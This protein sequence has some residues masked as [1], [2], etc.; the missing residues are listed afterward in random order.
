MKE[1]KNTEHRKRFIIDYKGTELLV[2]SLAV[3]IKQSLRPIF[4]E[5]CSLDPIARGGY[6]VLGMLLYPL[7]LDHATLNKPKKPCASCL[8]VDDA[9][10]SGARLA[11]A[12]QASTVDSIYIVL[13][14]A[15]QG[16]VDAI[17][18]AEPRVKQVFVAKIL[19]DLGPEKYGSEYQHWQDRRM[20]QLEGKRYWVGVPELVSFPWSE[21]DSVWWNDDTQQLE[22]GWLYRSPDQCLKNRSELSPPL[23]ITGRPEYRLPD[24]TAYRLKKEESVQLL[25]VDS[26]E[27]F[28]L[29]GTASTMWQALVKYG[30]TETTL[31]YLT[32]VYK[33]DQSLLKEDLTLFIDDA[34]SKRLLEKIV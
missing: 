30:E 34:I 7:D 8:I 13:L 27:L 33:V 18:L 25:D 5:H 26:D 28:E 10:F 24:N 11:K 9:A 23:A 29:E 2:S 20:Q 4:F 31:K 16:L 6:I 15:T 21:P 1:Y 14:T 19:K 17:M 12:I 32:N 22:R 3:T